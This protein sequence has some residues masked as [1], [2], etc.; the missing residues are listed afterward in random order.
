MHRQSKEMHRQS[1]ET[2]VDICRHSDADRLL[3]K[4]RDKR[5]TR[6]A[7]IDNERHSRT[8]KK[9][10]SHARTSSE[11]RLRFKTSV[12]QEGSARNI[13]SSDGRDHK[14]TKT[15]IKRQRKRNAD[16]H[17]KRDSVRNSD[18]HRNRRTNKR[19]K[20]NQFSDSDQDTHGMR[21]SRGRSTYRRRG[22]DRFGRVKRRFRLPIEPW[23]H[24]LYT[25]W[26]VT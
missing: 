14:Q 20:N 5:N 4:S 17:D 11:R 13:Q 19:R 1:K 21:D 10:H 26:F 25:R 2:K 6:H 9:K 24:Y 15:E 3:D 8:C 12:N 16:R 18:S 22:V 23:F 7:G